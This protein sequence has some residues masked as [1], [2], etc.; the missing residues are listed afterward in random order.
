MAIKKIRK[1]VVVTDD[2]PG[3][4]NEFLTYSSRHSYYTT[5]PNFESL[6]KFDTYDTVEEA[7]DRCNDADSGTL[8]GWPYP[9]RIM[10]ITGVYTGEG[11]PEMK[12]VKT[13]NE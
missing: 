2:G 10:E 5:T 12:L 8:G 6:T 1:Y 11:A 13:I 4:E 7:E 3:Y 9:F